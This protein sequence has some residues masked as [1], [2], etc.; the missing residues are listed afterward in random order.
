MTIGDAASELGPQILLGMVESRV[1]EA[2]CQ[3]FDRIRDKVCTFT[4]MDSRKEVVI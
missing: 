1:T 3:S 4:A 2:T